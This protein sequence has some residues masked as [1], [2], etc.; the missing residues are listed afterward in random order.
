MW[1]F[2]QV[3]TGKIGECSAT[4]SEKR[5]G[6]NCHWC[7]EGTESQRRAEG[8]G[9]V[10]SYHSKF[11]R[12]RESIKGMAGIKSRQDTWSTTGAPTA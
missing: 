8:L 10:K 3:T 11:R 2:E 6:A 4:G 1:V 5:R 12:E 7:Q 9:E